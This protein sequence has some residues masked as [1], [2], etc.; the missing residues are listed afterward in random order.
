MAILLLGS[1][2]EV[3]Y[4]DLMAGL[5]RDTDLLLVEPGPVTW[6]HRYVEDALEVSP[7]DREATMAAA[8]RLASAHQVS[9]ILTYL[10]PLLEIAADT[11]E[12][13]GVRGISRSAAAIVR[14]KSLQREAL[15]SAFLRPTRSI[16]VTSLAEARV[17]AAEIGF[18][19]VI[20]PRNFSG[21]LGVHFAATPELL[22]DAWRATIATKPRDAIVPA[23]GALV[24]E[25]LVGPH[26]SV[27]CWVL[28][29]EAG[30][31]ST[32]RAWD[33][34]SMSA[35]TG[36]WVMG[37]DL[38]SED[39]LARIEQAACQ[40]AIACGLDG[41]IADVEL[42][43]VDGEPRVLEVNGRPAG[44]QAVRM[45]ALSSGIDLGRALA[46]VAQGRRPDCAATASQAA[47]IVFVYPPKMMVFGG[48]RLAADLRVAEWL[49]RWHP[50]AKPGQKV[51]PPPED[52]WGRVGWLLVSGADATDVE[53]RMAAARR[54]VR[55]LEQSAELSARRE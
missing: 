39:V 50:T 13:A 51:T 15:S 34:H 26:F 44:D 47:G 22:D 29:G 20:K 32:S 42:I 49:D 21:G 23:A 19:V 12:R 24:E 46:T 53:K 35:L 43:L 25:L 18:P 16:R 6:Q 40:A 4:A 37:R 54:G 27:N 8:L 33:T 31:L 14:D 41:T 30:A 17:A 45:A 36:G 11:A 52:P 10:E 9:G 1:G 2:S 3:S 38:A 5:T 28:H 7:V 48:L 55:V